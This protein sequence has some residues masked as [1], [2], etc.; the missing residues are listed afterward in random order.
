MASRG[1]KPKKE[2]VDTEVVEKAPKIVEEVTETVEK[3]SEEEVTEPKIAEPEV[4][5]IA[6][7]EVVPEVIE[8]E[9]TEPEVEISEEESTLEDTLLDVVAASE[10]V[11]LPEFK[12]VGL[13]LRKL[14]PNL[15]DNRSKWVVELPTPRG[16]AHEIF[17]GSYAKAENA[18]KN[19]NALHDITI[20]ISKIR[21]K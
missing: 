8:A 6:E 20:P 7:S 2:V 10:P 18:A 19:W 16:G 13:R 1:R 17:R 14:N 11:D 4:T 15:A 3:S 21:S 9:V 12:E 5:E